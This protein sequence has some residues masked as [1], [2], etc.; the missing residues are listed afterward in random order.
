VICANCGTEN[1]PGAKFCN[2]CGGA[3]S[4]GCPSCGATNKP[5]ARF[6][7][8]C[9]TSLG[10]TGT[11]AVRPTIASTTAAPVAERRLV[12]VLFADIVGF[13]P[14]AEDKDAEEVR[15][16][17][18]RY[19]DMCTDIIGRYGGTVEK[20][21]G[22]AVMAVWGAPTAHEDDAERAV[23]AGLELV[24]AVRALGPDIQARVGILTG[25]AAVTLGAT[26]QGMVAG[27]MVNTA[28]RLQGVAQPDT[29]L[30][31]EATMRTTEAAIAFEPLGDQALKGKIAPVPAW[32][33]L[34]VVAERGGR[35]RAEAL[36]APFVGRDDELR[37]LK[38]LFHATGREKRTRLVSI[39]GPGGIGKSRL[40]WEFEKYMDG[41]SETIYW[42]RGRSPSYGE[43]ITFWALGEMIRG[44]A[45][46]AESDDE[47]TTR[48]KIAE[49][50]A[51]N[52]PDEAE[53][54]WIEP[55][56]LALLG[57]GT[58][59]G[60]DQLF[61]AWRTFFER[62]ASK[63]PVV[64]V[65]EDL[66][67]ADTGTIDFVEHVL[68]WSKGV[69]IFIVTLSRPE[70]IERRPDWGA[71]KRNFMSMY[72]E[73]LTEPAMRDLLAG[74]APGL[75]DGA[76]RSIIE[77]ADGMPL[78]AVETVRML[79]ADGKLVAENGAYH[80]V[81]D[82]AAL[83]VPETLTALIG[84]RLD[85]LDPADRS[86]LQGA[87]V[88]GQSF[89]MPALAAVAGEAETDIASRLAALVK[90]ELLTIDVDPRSPERGQYA[91]VQSVVREVAYN[92][93]AKRDRKA[94]HLAAARYFEGLGSDELAGALAT[95][96]LA[97][98]TNSPAGPEADAVAAQAR[99]A[100]RGAAERAIDLGSFAQ[101]ATFYDQ[102]R[103]ITTDTA[104]IADL[105]QRSGAAAGEAAQS[106]IAQSRL[107]EALDLRRVGADEAAELR[108]TTALARSLIVNFKVEE[109]IALLEPAAARWIPDGAE[110]DTDRV[111]LL[112]Q[113]SRVY[114]FHEE[115]ERAIAIADRALPVAE[116]LDAVALVADLLVTRGT[117]LGNLGR[118]YEGVGAIR[119]GRDLADAS[120]LT[121]TS[122]RATINLTAMGQGD[123][124]GSYQ[125]AR[126]A[127]GTALRLGRRSYARNLRMNATANAL[128]VGDW[129][130]AFEQWAT[131]LETETDELGLFVVRWNLVSLNA[132]R[133]DVASDEMAD[134]EAWATKNGD[135]GVLAGL[136]GLRADVAWAEGRLADACDALLRA[137]AGDALNA[138]T[139]TRAAGV[140]AL[141][142]RDADRAG[143][144]LAAFDA[145]GIHGRLWDLDR[146]LLQTGIGALIAPTGTELRS[147]RDVIDQLRDMGL[148]VRQCVAVL[149]LLATRGGDEPEVL[150]L[151]DEA[152]AIM[153]RLSAKPMLRELERLRATEPPAHMAMTRPSAAKPAP[154]AVRD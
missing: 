56:L 152:E 91:F 5:G 34:R 9:G 153:R 118:N 78:Y 80:P 18:S 40:A 69:P 125:I 72:L 53:R 4:A 121:A 137:A 131:E 117:A 82:L 66:H 102:A 154:A 8:E 46:L 76:T 115:H 17:L 20:F 65:F 24:D 16:T 79:V 86:L 10:E 116:R 71:G 26:N 94:G 151:G 37:L 12:T 135:P 108:A 97:A 98:H 136:E 6:C 113:L 7:N 109:A 28:A 134:L 142:A 74:L 27:D 42:H 14:F 150:A 141:I 133:G 85:G 127:L 83:A 68:D 87:A 95:H 120:G 49:T 62:L 114:F 61:A 36:E 77:R 111:E 75:P 13:T 132:S 54:R 124:A 35:N 21:I 19:F 89:T 122:L 145:T 96:Y 129:D 59:T 128:E 57:H 147:F 99:I 38:D 41:I 23:R 55:A 1:T 123:P 144:A 139:Q 15:D 119:A 45:G 88:L 140:A 130:W 106:A 112:S 30:V 93:L 107:R 126:T 84:A 3:L 146:Q 51:T 25:E 148:P 60:A 33:A 48:Q 22:D 103:R 105:L 73:P 70:L 67:W 32:R 58:S 149:V 92:T 100:L 81:G 143:Q 110:L 138:P 31:G 63:G 104:E 64:M 90:R 2:D 50:V 52:V 43:G 101:A 29:V 39:T 47:A 44:R 11:A